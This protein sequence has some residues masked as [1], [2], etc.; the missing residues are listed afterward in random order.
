[1]FPSSAVRYI[2]STISS[3]NA[4]RSPSPALSE[5]EIEPQSLLFRMDLEDGEVDPVLS[6][7]QEFKGL[8]Q[9]GRRSTL[10]GKPDTLLKLK[11]EGAE[12]ALNVTRKVAPTAVPVPDSIR[13]AL[14]HLRSMIDAKWQSI[15]SQQSVTSQ[16]D[17]SSSS[18]WTRTFLDH[19]APSWS[20]CTLPEPLVP[21]WSKQKLDWDA[22]TW[23][24]PCCPPVV[25]CSPGSPPVIPSHN[26]SESP[27]FPL[28]PMPP[29]SPINQSDMEISDED[30]FYATTGGPHTSPTPLIDPVAH[31]C[32]QWPKSKPDF[33]GMD[34]HPPHPAHCG[35]F[36]GDGF[37]YN[38]P[39]F[40]AFYK[41]LIENPKTHRYVV[42]PF[43]KYH[44]KPS[45]PEVSYTWG[46]GHPIMTRL[47]MPV[48]VPYCTAL[49]TADQRTLFCSSEPFATAIDEV[50]EQMDTNDLKAGVIQYRHYRDQ[51]HVLHT[52]IQN[53]SDTLMEVKEHQIKALDNLEAANAFGCLHAHLGWFEGEL[54]DSPAADRHLKQ[55]FASHTLTERHIKLVKPIRRQD[56]WCKYH[57]WGNHTT[58]QCNIFKKCCTCKVMGHVAINCPRKPKH[59]T[60]KAAHSTCFHK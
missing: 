46:H 6:L 60:P 57:Q 1:M 17:D 36:P 40:N 44:L 11:K 55:V 34:S 26:V 12:A 30:E 10:M 2:A 52:K 35:L 48:P 19:K 39:R 8:K 53:M 59:H 42:A 47:L 27:N 20:T 22:P 41:V 13:E 7:L 45:Y 5:G 18:S 16:D 38:K 33:E 51:C 24:A 15:Q 49:L 58:N 28:L 32:C 4:T 54:M 21:D 50:L 56:L 3:T 25:P 37:Q 9:L 14:E 29:V 43:I 23:D 31:K